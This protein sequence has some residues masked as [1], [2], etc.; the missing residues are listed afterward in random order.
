MLRARATDASVAGHD[1]APDA[2]DELAFAA[3]DA[4]RVEADQRGVDKGWTRGR[5][6]SGVVGVFPAA[7]AAPAADPGDD[8]ARLPRRAL[9]DAYRGAGLSTLATSFTSAAAF[10]SLAFS[11][12][13][14]IRAFGIFAG[15]LVCVQFVLVATVFPA[16]LALN[17]APMRAARRRADRRAAADAEMREAAAEAADRPAAPVVNPLHSDR[18]PDADAPR[19][20]RAAAAARATRVAREPRADV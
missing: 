15:T 13:P 19:F 2:D 10:F 7:Y 17:G 20:P 11:Q 4:L 14:V 9:A 12:M 16:A 1:C 3:G 5:N 8:A 6:A 18:E